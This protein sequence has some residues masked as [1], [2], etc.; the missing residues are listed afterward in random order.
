VL[1]V[2]RASYDNDVIYVQF[3]HGL[4]I[5]YRTLVFREHSDFIITTTVCRG[6]WGLRALHR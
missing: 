2:K 4:S 3:S 6:G 5:L 1:A